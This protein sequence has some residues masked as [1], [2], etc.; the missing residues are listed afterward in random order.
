MHA[1][2]SDSF[3]N[4]N[5]MSIKS[6]FKNPNSLGLKKQKRDATLES[7]WTG[8]SWLP[9]TSKWN[10]K[11]AAGKARS[12]LVYIVIERL[13][14]LSRAPLEVE[15]KR[16]PK[17]K[18]SC[19]SAKEAVPPRA[20]P[21]P[22]TARSLALP[23]PGGHGR[24]FLWRDPQTLVPGPSWGRISAL[25]TGEA[26]VSILWVAPPT[27]FSKQSRRGLCPSAT[28]RDSLGNLYSLKG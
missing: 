25:E 24:C 4:P 3:L 5:K 9:G 23:H 12:H 15:E 2:A 13:R 1:L 27:W 6:F 18:A 16:G 7:A 22:H 21:R 11:A 26:K 10:P 19:K 20:L 14:T 17:S 8:G 28:G